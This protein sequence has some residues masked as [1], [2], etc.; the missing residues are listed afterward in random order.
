[1]ILRVNFFE[2][3]DAKLRP[4]YGPRNEHLLAVL[5]LLA[6]SLLNTFSPAFNQSTLNS[7]IYTMYYL[8]GKCPVNLTNLG[9]II[10][11]TESTN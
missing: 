9:F 2:K 1:M 10:D 5:T 8:S 11:L 7:V 3:T 4:V 6:Y